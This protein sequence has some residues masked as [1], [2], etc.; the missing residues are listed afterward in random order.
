MTIF[1]AYQYGASASLVVTWIE[2]VQ[3]RMEWVIVRVVVV[4]RKDVSAIS[5]ALCSKNVAKH[6]VY[7]F[8]LVREFSAHTDSGI[9]GLRL[10]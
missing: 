7:S 6:D 4:E 8:K 10:S 5:A 9:E 2:Q 3:R 1:W